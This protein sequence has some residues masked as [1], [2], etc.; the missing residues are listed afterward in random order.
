MPALFLPPHLRPKAI[1][2]STKVVCAA[3]MPDPD[4][5][6]RKRGNAAGPLKAALWRFQLLSN[7]K[8]GSRYSYTHLGVTTKQSPSCG[9]P[10]IL[11]HKNARNPRFQRISSASASYFSRLFRD[12]CISGSPQLP[13]GPPGPAGERKPLSAT[14]RVPF[15]HT[16]SSILSGASG[17]E[18]RAQ[19]RFARS[20]ESKYT[21]VS[22][23]VGIFS[24]FARTLI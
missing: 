18:M 6:A 23:L 15:C 8:L 9:S 22:R 3:A 13:S 24:S 2:V 12:L 14:L 1:N 5:S 19:M 21:L 11:A 16:D 7:Q 4:R 10:R 20:T 17:A